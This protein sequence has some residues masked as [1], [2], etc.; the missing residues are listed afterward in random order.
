MRRTAVLGAVLLSLMVPRE[1]LA[2]DDADALIKHGLLLRRQGK[3]TEA[4][5]DFRRAYALE[6]TPRGQAQIA[7]AEQAL[8]H[9]L[10]AEA[11]LGH[12]LAASQDAWIVANRGLLE[13]GLANIRGRL[14]WL[15]VTADVPDAELWVNDARVGTLPLAHP[16]R[17]EAGNA[18]IEVRAAGYAA[19]RRLTTI[20][21]GGGAREAVHLVPLPEAAVAPPEGRPSETPAERV[22]V[23]PGQRRVQNVGFVVAG[24][25]VLGLSLGAYF[26]V[27]TLQLKHDRDV[28]CLGAGGTCNGDAAA[29]SRQIAYDQE[30]RTSALR[31]TVWIGAGVVALVTGVGLLW[32]S[33]SHTIHERAGELRL[34]P[35]VGPDR[36]GVGLQGSW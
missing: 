4:L 21:P 12:A 32:V 23:V 30:A 19:A 6:P 9:W 2:D 18:V 35:E 3:D 22:R 20:D 14:G 31:S 29:Y 24:A 27:L 11:D 25:G 15:E 16:V 13:S 7:L 34:L 10:E 36:A 1:A 17:L 5:D 28:A 8:G 33:R 26:G